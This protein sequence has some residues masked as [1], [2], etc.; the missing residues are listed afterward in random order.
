MGTGGGIWREYNTK[1][2]VNFVWARFEH[3]DGRPEE[4]RARSSKAVRVV[5]VTGLAGR[6]PWRGGGRRVLRE[7]GGAW[8]RRSIREEPV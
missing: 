5:R 3:D 2:L 7:V 1:R 8:F 4:P 6:G